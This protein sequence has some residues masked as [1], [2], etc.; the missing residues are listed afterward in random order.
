MYLRLAACNVRGIGVFEAV[1]LI[2]GGALVFGVFPTYLSTFFSVAAEFILRVYVRQLL[3]NPSVTL[4]I[5]ASPLYPSV[6]LVMA[7]PLSYRRLCAR[8][9]RTALV[10]RLK[11]YNCGNGCNC[12]RKQEP[13]TRNQK[14][15]TPQDFFSIFF[16]NFLQT[17]RR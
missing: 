10:F 12:A 17:V 16:L 3:D 7:A 4:V 9:C 1:I 15:G 13:E 6:A 14:L 2:I 11:A 5:T 8:H